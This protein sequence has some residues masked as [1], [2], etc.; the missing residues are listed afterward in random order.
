M[1]SEPN[2][3]TLA[4]YR[5]ML[6]AAYGNEQSALAAYQTFVD[7]RNAHGMLQLN[8]IDSL[9]EFVLM[10]AA[11]QATRGQFSCSVRGVV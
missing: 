5:R 10:G 8:P 4:G 1:T 6:I 9:K 3:R 2:E 11:H 7:Y